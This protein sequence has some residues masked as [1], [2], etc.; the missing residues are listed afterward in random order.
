MFQAMR[1]CLRGFWAPVFQHQGH[2]EAVKIQIFQLFSLLWRRKILLDAYLLFTLFSS[3]SVRRAFRTCFGAG[4]SHVGRKP[5]SIASISWTK[6][7]KTVR[8]IYCKYCKVQALLANSCLFSQR[9]LPSETTAELEHS[10]FQCSQFPQVS[11]LVSH[12]DGCW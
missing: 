7:L 4:V 2:G 12:L 8:T 3:W 11:R 1:G 10:I 5:D 6:S 9:L